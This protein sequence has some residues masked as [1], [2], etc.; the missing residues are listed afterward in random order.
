MYILKNKVTGD[1]YKNRQD[2]LNSSTF[3]IKDLEA[4]WPEGWDSINWTEEP[5]EPLEELYKQRALQLR[6][7]YDYLILYYS[8]GSD[9]STVLN[10]F[11]KYN[12]PLDEVI[13]NRFADHDLLKLPYVVPDY[14]NKITS[15]NI[16]HDFLQDFHYNQ[17]WLTD[18]FGYSGLMHTLSRNEIYFFEKH[19]L[20]KTLTR[21]G[22]VAHI[23][24]IDKPLIKIVNNKYYCTFS[25]NTI[26]FNE[27][28]Q[29]EYKEHFFTSE[30]FPKLHAKQCHII[31][32]WCKIKYPKSTRAVSE[33]AYP[34][35]RE[36]MNRLLRDP[37]DNRNDPGG[38]SA[39]GFLNSITNIKTEVGKLLSIYK[40]DKFY[41]TY[42]NGVVKSY[43][44]TDSAI[45]LMKFTKQ[46]DIQLIDKNLEKRIYLGDTVNEQ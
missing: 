35:S 16:T 1:I 28:N 34:D 10:I 6:G 39:G 23:Y 7:S 31:M 45:K 30:N 32:N 2:I 5:S 20:I 13:T 17:K 24:G 37:F 38:S 22:N 15:I 18:G 9:S 11:K 26:N 41:D 43:F 14:G 25:S 12:I 21:K 42:V 29:H 3:N 40:K 36:I 27:H 19:N 33:S 4:I 44:N 8:G 46:K